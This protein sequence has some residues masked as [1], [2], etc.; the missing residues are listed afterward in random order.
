MLAKIR[1]AAL[2][3]F[4]LGFVP[5]RFFGLGFFGL[6]FVPLRFFQAQPALTPAHTQHPYSASAKVGSENERVIPAAVMEWGGK[7]TC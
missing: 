7:A 4:R 1:P 5:L 3:F 6:G 2:E